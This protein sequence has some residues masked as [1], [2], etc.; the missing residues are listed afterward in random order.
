MIVPRNTPPS[1]PRTSSRNSVVGHSIAYGPSTRGV[2]T[3]RVTRHQAVS[4][5]ASKNAV[6]TR[7]AGAAIVAEMSRLGTGISSLSYRGDR[8]DRSPKVL[9]RLRDLGGSIFS[10]L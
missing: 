6:N 1:R 2:V 7:G 5:S 8:K 9:C 10:G 4:A 3:E